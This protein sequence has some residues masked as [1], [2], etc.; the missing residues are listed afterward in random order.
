MLNCECCAVIPLH[1]GLLGPLN[2]LL[3]RMAA[4]RDEMMNHIAEL[5]SD[6]YTWLF[7]NDWIAGLVRITVTIG[8][9]LLVLVTLICCGVPLLRTLISKL[10]I[11]IHHYCLCVCLSTMCYFLFSLS[12][13][14]YFVSILS[15]VCRAMANDD[16]ADLQRQEQRRHIPTCAVLRPAGWPTSSVHITGARFAS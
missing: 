4:A 14:V 10:S 3:D 11:H 1:T 2:T 12:L 6:W 15:V 8:L 16:R 5:E 7:S 9:V 13:F